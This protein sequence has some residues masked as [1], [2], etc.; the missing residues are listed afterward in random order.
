[1]AA[2]IRK[3]H[4]EEVKAKIQASQLINLLQNHAL[5]DN[6]VSAT[7]IDAAKFLLNKLISNAAVVTETDLAVS[8]AMDFRNII[9]QGVKAGD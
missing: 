4:Q 8:G 6:D 3:H 9:I 7:R 5:E 2:R 1:M